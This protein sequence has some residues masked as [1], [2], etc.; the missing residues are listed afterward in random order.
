[1]ICNLDFIETNVNTETDSK[2]EEKQHLK[3]VNVT[4]M[5][6]LVVYFKNMHVRKLTKA[7]ASYLHRSFLDT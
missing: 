5:Y 1:M 7:R 4:Y 2:G 3:Y 6:I